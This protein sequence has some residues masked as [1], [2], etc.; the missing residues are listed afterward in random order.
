MAAMATSGHEIEVAEASAMY[1]HDG[2]AF[3]PHDGLAFAGP[4]VPH[5]NALDPSL[6]HCRNLVGKHVVGI[7]R[8]MLSQKPFLA[9]DGP[10]AGALVNWQ[11]QE[12]KTIAHLL[13]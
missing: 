8:G 11:S 12:F 9:S 3:Y 5:E 13:L 10:A 1:P 7:K 6:S 4:F 2:L